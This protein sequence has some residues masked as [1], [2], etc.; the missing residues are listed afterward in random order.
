MKENKIE[1]TLMTVEVVAEMVMVSS[2]ST[3]LLIFYG[4]L[5]VNQQT[6]VPPEVMP[7]LLAI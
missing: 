1:D 5:R 7:R 6:L 4:E 3:T 2:G